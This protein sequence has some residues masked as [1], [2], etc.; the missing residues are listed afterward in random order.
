QDPDKFWKKRGKKLSDVAE[1]FTNRRKAM[2]QAV[3]QIV[4]PNDP[5]ETK[6]RKIYARVQQVRNTSYEAARTEQEQKR[7]KDK[8]GNV[9]DVWKA[10]AADGY[11]ITWLFLGLARAAGL[12]ASP[13]M[14]ATRN[15]HFFNPKL[16]RASDLNTNMVQVKLNGKDL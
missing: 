3:A 10:G 16:M 12:E 14:V 2:E 15:D 6:L 9:E 7:N 8:I 1:S 5:P 4:S 13:V 11:Q